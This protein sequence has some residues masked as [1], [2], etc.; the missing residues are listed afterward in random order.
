MARRQSK[1]P[2]EYYATPAWAVQAIRPVLAPWLDWAGQDIDLLDPCAGPRAAIAKGLLTQERDPHQRWWV[3]DKD[4]AA[5]DQLEHLPRVYAVHGDYL[6]MRREWGAPL[7]TA[8]NPPFSQAVDFAIRSLAEAAPCGV[9]AYLQRLN[10]RRATQEREAFWRSCP[11]DV[12]VLNRRPSFTIDGKTDA[13]EYAWY[14]WNLTVPTDQRGR[15]YSLE[16]P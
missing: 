2:L 5:V 15:I 8:A 11:A 4:R 1:D 6:T 3:V 9:V 16:Y 14:V 13:S 10:W 12:Y 7:V